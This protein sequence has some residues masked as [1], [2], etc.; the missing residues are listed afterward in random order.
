[1]FIGR[2]C[3]LVQAIRSIRPCFSRSTRPRGVRC[4]SGIFPFVHAGVLL[5]DV[6]KG[7]R[8][9]PGEL[10]DG[11]ILGDKPLAGYDPD[12]GDHQPEFGRIADRP[13]DSGYRR[14]TFGGFLRLFRDDFGHVDPHDVFARF[15]LENLPV[16]RP[17]VNKDRP[18]APAVAESRG[19]A[20]F[21]GGFGRVDVVVEIVQARAVRDDIFTPPAR[22]AGGEMGADATS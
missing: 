1:M 5:D 11:R 17:G 18:A 21:M 4:P 20:G 19:H 15:E 7:R 2:P 22:Q 16:G 10:F 12:C 14:A 8:K 3:A 9:N 13:F 6:A